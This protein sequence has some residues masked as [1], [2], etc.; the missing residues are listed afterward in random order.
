LHDSWLFKSSE[1]GACLNSSKLK[2]SDGSDV[3]EYV[4]GDAGYPLLPWLLTPYQL[5]KDILLS[6][7]K[8]EFNSR[9]H[10]AIVIA[11]KE[12]TGTVERHVEVHA[13]RRVAS[14]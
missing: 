2:L 9:H 11:Q 7:S 4:I 1:N 5:E 14:K 3:G 10:G 12:G 13:G 8:V 6:D